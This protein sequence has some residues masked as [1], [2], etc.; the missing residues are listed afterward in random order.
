MGFFSGMS[1][2]VP[3]LGIAEDVLRK[4]PV[5]KAHPALQG[6][7]D[8]FL[9]TDVN[10][11]PIQGG[12]VAQQQVYQPSYQT[13]GNW[14]PQ[15][16]LPEH[17]RN[18]RVGLNQ[19]MPS[20]TQTPSPAAPTPTTDGSFMPMPRMVD[21]GQRMNTYPRFEESPGQP[22]PSPNWQGF[23]PGDLN[24]QG[25]GY[26]K[27]PAQFSPE[28]RWGLDSFEGREPTQ[29]E[30]QSYVN[31]TVKQWGGMFTGGLGQSW[32]WGQ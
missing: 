20:Y 17:L 10:G 26:S 29:E 21:E 15:E 2:F 8:H 5:A 11:N 16:L 22:I 27:Q 28:N 30:L 13:T 19:P 3:G 12:G 31:N 6:A 14:T 4:H 23:K 9:G 18:T 1:S 7:A 25:G 32:G 24:Y